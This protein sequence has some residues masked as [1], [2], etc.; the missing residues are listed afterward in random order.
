MFSHLEQKYNDGKH[1][2]LH[3]VTAREAYNIVR[4]AEDG[5]SGDPNQYRD[6]LVPHP[7]N[8]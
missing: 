7:L 4:A 6:Y 8:R 2:L 3:Y 1:Y 5:H